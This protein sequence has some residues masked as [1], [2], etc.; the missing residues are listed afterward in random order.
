MKQIYTILALTIISLNTMAGRPVNALKSD[1]WWVDWSDASAW[2]LNRVPASGDSVVITKDH[3]VVFD[4]AASYTN[5]YI[6]VIGTL[7]VRKTMTLDA[8][9]AVNIPS[10]G[11]VYRFGASPTTEIIVIGGKKKFDQTSSTNIYGVGLANSQSGIAPLGFSPSA[12]LPVTFSG[13][14]VTKTSNGVA[15][16]WSTAQEFNNSNFDIQRSA[17]GVNWTLIATVKGA[18]NS[19]TEKQY[20]YTDK[21]SIGAVAYYRIRQVDIDG[22]YTY[23]T[24]KTIR[25]NEAAPV[26][27]VYATGKNVNVEFNTAVKNNITVRLLNTNGQVVMQQNYQQSAYKITLNTNAN[28]GLYIVQVTDGKEWN[29]ATKVIL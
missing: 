21:M 9:S 29:E 12:S 16:N 4:V 18:G 17:D 19:N 14:Y 28:T 1:S 15:L 13:F 23:S 10:G 7:S 25:S 11:R 22:Q 20:S 26:A 2:T 6:N 8:V 5:M 27:K 24:V 3:G